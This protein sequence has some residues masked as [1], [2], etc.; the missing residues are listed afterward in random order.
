MDAPEAEVRRERAAFIALVAA[1]DA[2]R[3]E[4]DVSS[5]AKGNLIGRSDEEL[6]ALF[7]ALHKNSHVTL[8]TLS[9]PR[10]ST[11]RLLE[12]TLVAN[13]S[14]S[15]NWCCNF[16]QSRTGHS[17]RGRSRNITCCNDSPSYV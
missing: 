1:N 4:A 5:A 14:A 2:R 8:L 11:M 16:A 7:R 15:L 9:D 13:G 17:W 10:E 12:S 3:T 6:E